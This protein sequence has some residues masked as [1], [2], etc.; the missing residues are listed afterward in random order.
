[1]RAVASTLVSGGVDVIVSRGGTATRA[2]VEAT[3]TIPIVALTGSDYVAA[4][5]AA[6]MAR[7]GG[8]ITGVSSITRDLE[9]KRL[10]LVRESLPH[11]RRIAILYSP[12]SVAGSAE[13]RRMGARAEEMGFSV[14]AREVHRI[15]DFAAAVSA[16]AAAGPAVLMP[17]A[18]TLLQTASAQR[19]LGELALR[20]RMPGAFVEPDAVR[21]GGLLSYGVD[22]AA[23]WV[24]AAEYADRILRG[25]KPGDLPI[26]EPTRLQLVVNLATARTL[27]ITL[28]PTVVAR[29]DEVIE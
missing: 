11:F 15:D 24:R 22:V 21:A 8:N 23:M 16:L 25:A 7:P 20:H 17:V 3:R 4:G 27:G 9:G 2:A 6:S 26:E 5:Y 14:D 1:M 13:A 19:R 29:A 28:P 10:D 12:D 18:A